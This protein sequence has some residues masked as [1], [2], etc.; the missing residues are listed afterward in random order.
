MVHQAIGEASRIAISTSFTKSRDSIAVIPVTEAPN[1]LRIPI[2]F[3]LNS[4]I[5]DASPSKPRQD[6][7]MANPEKI[8]AN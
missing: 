3:V 5:Y 8:S 6:I 1:T 7:K 2:S 4:A